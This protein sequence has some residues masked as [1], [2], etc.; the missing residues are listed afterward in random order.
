MNRTDNRKQHWDIEIHTQKMDFCDSHVDLYEPP[1]APRQSVNA[2]QAFNVSSHPGSCIS[3][4]V[5]RH[6]ELLVH[7]C[8]MTAVPASRLV[9]GEFLSIERMTESTVFRACARGQLPSLSTRDVSLI[10]SSLEGRYCALVESAG[11]MCSLQLDWWSCRSRAHQPG[12]LGSFFSFGPGDHWPGQQLLAGS[13]RPPPARRC[14]S[15]LHPAAV[16]KCVFRFFC[17]HPQRHRCKPLVPQEVVAT[18]RPAGPE[19]CDHFCALCPW[20]WA[21]SSS[22]AS[23]P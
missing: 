22:S 10:S 17:H 1:S 7:F 23:S 5:G 2:R 3:A 16:L 20:A 9:I 14:R 11:D 8:S 6:F 18:A 13:A 12:L 19:R 21:S 4:G 15:A